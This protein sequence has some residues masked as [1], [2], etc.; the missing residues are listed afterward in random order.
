ME[1]SCKKLG[2]HGGSHGG[3]M[4]DIIDFNGISWTYHR[5]SNKWDINRD[6]IGILMMV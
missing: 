4:G 1:K 2:V 6:I 3:F 5:I